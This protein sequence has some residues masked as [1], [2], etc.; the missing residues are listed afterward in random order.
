MKVPW[1]ALLLLLL[2]GSAPTQVAAPQAFSL[3]QMNESCLCIATSKQTPTLSADE[4]SSEETKFQVFR[5][6]DRPPRELFRVKIGTPDDHWE[7]YGIVDEGDFNGDGV[8]DYSWYGRDDSSFAMYLFISSGDHRYRRVD[9]I[10][11]V[12]AAWQAK[13]HRPAPSLGIIDGYFTL[14]DLRLE[15]RSSRD[16]T[17]LASVEAVTRVKTVTVTYNFGIA[18]KDFK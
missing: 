4:D 10:N 6:K 9:V 7:R 14:K 17:L 15:S 12:R 3:Y 5:S 1:T 2:S 13:F 16:L 11:T 8:P 18:E